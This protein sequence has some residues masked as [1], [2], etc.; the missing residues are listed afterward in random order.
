MHPRWQAVTQAFN[1]SETGRMVAAHQS[2]IYDH[3]SKCVGTHWAYAHGKS[4]STG[5]RIMRALFKA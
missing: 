5:Y 3:Q 4:E 2:D 1:V